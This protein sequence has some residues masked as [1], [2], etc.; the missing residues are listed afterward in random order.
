MINTSAKLYDMVLWR[1]LSLWF[2]PYREQ[3]GSQKQRSCTEHIVTLRILSDVARRKKVKL[4]I[5]FTYFSKSYDLVP[6][7]KLFAVLRRIGCGA[8]M[9]AVLKAMYCVTG[10]LVGAV[11]PW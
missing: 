5:T 3:A 8:V 1:R 4:F 6:R 7:Q 2:R 10:S 9:L 11:G